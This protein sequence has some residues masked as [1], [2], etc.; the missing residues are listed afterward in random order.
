MGWI[1]KLLFHSVL[2]R[3]YLYLPLCFSFEI[4]KYSSLKFMHTHNF[5]KYMLDIYVQSI[6]FD[7]VFCTNSM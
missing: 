3:Q 5:G 2:H 1:L 6:S 7:A 4:K